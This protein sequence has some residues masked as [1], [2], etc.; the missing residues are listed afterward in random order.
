MDA[1]EH[2]PS[3]LDRRLPNAKNTHASEAPNPGD[4]ISERPGDFVGIRIL[5]RLV[6]F[7]FQLP[8][9]KRFSR[10]PSMFDSSGVKVPYP[11]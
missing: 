10:V 3:T 7:T 1:T 2:S 8:T 6:F 4:I 11:T 9:A 5:P